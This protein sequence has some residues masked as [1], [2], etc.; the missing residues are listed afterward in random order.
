MTKESKEKQLERAVLRYCLE[1]DIE[2]QYGKLS[3]CDLWNHGF[4]RPRRRYQVHCED[5]KFKFSMIY[6]ELGPA[7][8]KFS[9]IKKRIS[10]KQ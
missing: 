1:H 9:Y 8:E 3:L 4:R 5:N 2:L 7:V 6:D 10:N